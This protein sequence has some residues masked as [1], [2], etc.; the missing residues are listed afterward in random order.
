MAKRMTKEEKV[1]EAAYYD[2]FRR[3]GSNVQ[4]DMFDLGKIHS[5]SVA[6]AASGTAMDDA[7]K[8]AVAKYRKN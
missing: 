8:A 6:A 7:V 1:L 3:L 4:F 2:A 5:E